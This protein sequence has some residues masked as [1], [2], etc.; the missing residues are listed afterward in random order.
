MP[1]ANRPPHSR[2]REFPER[3]REGNRG[4]ADMMHEVKVHLLVEDRSLLVS[5]FHPEPVVEANPSFLIGPWDP[6]VKA[7]FRHDPNELDAVIRVRREIT[8][9]TGF[10]FRMSDDPNL[11]GPGHLP[12]P[13]P[14]KSRLGPQTWSARMANNEDLHKADM[15]SLVCD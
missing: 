15:R 10:V 8:V 12:S 3:R 7:A 13:V 11:M 9:D 6:I 14:G 2:H 1:S 4:P 5:L